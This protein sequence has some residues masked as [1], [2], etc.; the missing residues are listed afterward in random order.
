MTISR[1]S[2][3]NGSIVSALVIATGCAADDDD[4]EDGADE[5]GGGDCSGGATA[6][7]GTNHGHSASVSGADV[8][9]GAA[10]SYDITGSSPHSHMISLSAGDMATLAGGASVMVTSTS[11]GADGHTHAVTLL[12]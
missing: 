11:G 12:C 1:K 8:A 9:A 3:V 6:N 4:G 5:S 7:I 10:K 2:F